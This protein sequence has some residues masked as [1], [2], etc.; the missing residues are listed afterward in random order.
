MNPQGT[1]TGLYWEIN[2]K[3][4]DAEARKHKKASVVS[5]IKTVVPT[6]G[7]GLASAIIM[8]EITRLTGSDLLE[9]NE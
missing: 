2:F 8:A 5:D 4:V 6:S 9:G 7:V 3:V 1:S